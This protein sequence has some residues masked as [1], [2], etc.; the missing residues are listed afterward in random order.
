MKQPYVLIVEDDKDL[1]DILCQFIEDEF[2]IECKVSTTC[3]EAISI[4]R[5]IR[6]CLVLIDYLLN[7]GPSDPL[8]EFCH[9][10]NINFLFMTA[11][12]KAPLIAKQMEVPILW[13]PFNL[14]N[15]ENLVKKYISVQKIDTI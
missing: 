9:Q 11:A 12:N 6:P 2:S 1:G 5:S 7:D 8:L 3:K 13:K 15:L 10:N 14:N 4:S